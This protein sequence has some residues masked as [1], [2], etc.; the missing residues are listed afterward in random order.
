[1]RQRRNDQ[2]IE[3]RD[4]R[5]HRFTLRWRNIRQLRFQVARFD[6]GEHRKF[7]NFFEVISDPIDQ[8]V[9]QATKVVRAHIAQLGRS[10][11]QVCFHG[12]HLNRSVSHKEAQK[13]Q[14]IFLL[15][16]RQVAKSRS[17]TSEIC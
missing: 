8:F 7:F 3:I 13:A 14:I 12:W 11:G 1:M 10:M 4:D 5:F 15:R 17:N 9:A 16:G 2:A 6:C